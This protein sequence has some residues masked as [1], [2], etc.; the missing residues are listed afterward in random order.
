MC[1]CEVHGWLISRE[2][3]ERVYLGRYLVPAFLH[4]LDRALVCTK[5]AYVCM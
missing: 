1:V 5:C 4:V 2:G 3:F